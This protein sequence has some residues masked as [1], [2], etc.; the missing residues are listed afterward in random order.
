MALYSR[1]D[2]TRAFKLAVYIVFSGQPFRLRLKKCEKYNCIS[3][4]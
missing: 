1:T 3:S 2:R 4:E